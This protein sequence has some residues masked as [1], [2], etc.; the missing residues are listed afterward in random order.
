MMRFKKMIAANKACTCITLAAMG[1]MAGMIVAKVM[2]D[3]CCCCTIKGKAKKALKN[4]EE[5]F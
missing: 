2:V 3:H 1:A 4:M 5:M